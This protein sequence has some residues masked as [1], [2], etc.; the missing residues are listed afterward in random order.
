MAIL[1]VCAS[2]RSAFS[3]R[4]AAMVDFAAPSACTITS[5]SSALSAS[6]ESF[7]WTEFSRL[8]VLMRH[9]MNECRQR[10]PW[11]AAGL[12][13][14][15]NRFDKRRLP[16]VMRSREGN[17]KDRRP[18]SP[19]P[20]RSKPGVDPGREVERWRFQP[21]TEW[22]FSQHHPPE[23]KRHEPSEE[24]FHRQLESPECASRPSGLEHE[25]WTSCAVRGSRSARTRHP[26]HRSPERNAAASA[27]SAIAWDAV[28]P[29][30]SITQP[31]C[32]YTERGV[33]PSRYQAADLRSAPGRP[34]RVQWRGSVRRGLGGAQSPTG[35]RMR[36]ARQSCGR[37]LLAWCALN[38]L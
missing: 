28:R 25:Q 10:I 37:N 4:E 38:S 35:S 3:S 20:E 21:V 30:R 2:P 22:G 19:N 36:D 24:V 5:S 14:P 31:P 33:P 27:S 6:S 15:G 23:R 11:P 13:R 7:T 16:A 12:G 29:I 8:S 1:T 18:G 9:P 34:W 17:K 26:A 32:R